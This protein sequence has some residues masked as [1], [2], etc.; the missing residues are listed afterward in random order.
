MSENHSSSSKPMPTD[1]LLDSL[2]DHKAY[3]LVMNQTNTH[4]DRER[5]F[6]LSMCPPAGPPLGWML[7]T[8]KLHG[9]HH[10]WRN[11]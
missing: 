6:P 4:L 11:N 7:K 9:C 2:A 1:F 10:R 8:D 5:Q 3:C